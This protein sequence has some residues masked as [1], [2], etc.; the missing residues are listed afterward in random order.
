MSEGIVSGR[1]AKVYKTVINAVFSQLKVKAQLF[2]ELKRKEQSRSA[3][4]RVE[5]GWLKKRPFQEGGP[6]RAM[7]T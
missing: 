1:E 4:P 6:T 2:I 3:T 7:G 5:G